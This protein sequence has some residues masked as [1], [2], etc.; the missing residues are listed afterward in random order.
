MQ[1]EVKFSI[2]ILYLREQ[3]KARWYSA[4]AGPGSH[5]VEKIGCIPRGLTRRAAVGISNGNW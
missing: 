1:I 3:L 5:K 2:Q 4:E